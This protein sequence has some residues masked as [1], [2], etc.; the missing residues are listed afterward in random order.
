MCAHSAEPLNLP[1]ISHLC[2]GIL[3]LANV[4]VLSLA[5]DFLPEEQAAG[6]KQEPP[7]EGAWISQQPSKK[8]GRGFQPCSELHIQGRMHYHS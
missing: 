2:I 7:Q 4:V 3:C 8:N 1:L 6:N 5:N